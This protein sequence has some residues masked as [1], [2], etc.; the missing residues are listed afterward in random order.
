M[1]NRLTRSLLVGVVLFAAPAAMAACASDEQQVED[2]V[3]SAITDVSNQV[4]T[5]LSDVENQID[6]AGRDTAELAAR[7][8]ATEQ[9]EK[10]F[11]NA[12]HPLDGKL[13]CTATYM[14]DDRIAIECSGKTK[15]GEDAML[16]GTTEETTL[17]EVAEVKGEFVGTVAG[18]EV[19]R[20]DKLGV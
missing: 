14:D 17:A 19:F 9:G 5:A 4:E 10:E 20:L 11:D 2:D 12:G 8:L 16:V 3:E 7:T 18:A 13:T 15:A 1:K 6:E